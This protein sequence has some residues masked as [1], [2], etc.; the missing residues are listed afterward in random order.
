MK[1]YAN[2]EA[3]LEGT[4][5]TS[6]H[7][8][9]GTSVSEEILEAIRKRFAE[10]HR[11]A[12]MV[13]DDRGFERESVRSYLKLFSRI[14]NRGVSI[15]MTIVHF[16]LGDVANKRLK[17]LSKTE[18]ALVEFARMSLMEP[19][20]CFC[21]R[22]LGNLDA[23]ARSV[24]LLWIAEMIEKG[25]V[26]VTTAEPLREALLMPGQIF[27]FDEGRFI[28]ADVEQDDADGNAA[29]SGA[30]SG[31]EVDGVFVG[32]EVRICKIAVKTESATLLLDPK[33]IDFI[34]SMSKANYASVRGSLYQTNLTMDELETELIRFGF[35]RC[36]RSYIVNAQKVA[37][38]ERYTRNS[39]N[40]TLNDAAESS[41]PLAKGR[42]EEMRA[43]YG[44]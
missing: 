27:W 29:T 1:D 38:V 11:C 21:E 8:E 20:V 13:G 31:W 42:A 23:T 9:C 32:D 5:G 28:A 15:D 19:E 43:R 6:V 33:D 24:T 3:L 37:K 35:F 2:I 40:L 17:V 44:W 26:F 30:E 18:R 12:F 16:G 34:E 39:F 4:E 10:T 22:P 14:A 25:T 7:I 36:H 41:I